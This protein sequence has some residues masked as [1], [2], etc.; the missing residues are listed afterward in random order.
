[1]SPRAGRRYIVVSGMAAL[2]ALLL[3]SEQAEHWSMSH[4]MSLVVL[5]YCSSQFVGRA[6]LFEVAAV[7]WPGR[8]LGRDIFS[9]L[10]LYV[11]VLKVSR[12]RLL[13][14]FLSFSWL[15]ISCVASKS[16]KPNSTRRRLGLA[17]AIKLINHPIMVAYS[18]CARSG[19]VLFYEGAAEKMLLL[20]TKEYG[21]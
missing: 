21:L 16:L 12:S 4:D 11:C 13:P 17:D 5:G 18:N 19:D 3:C 2:Y 10:A 9:L 8:G 7:Q 14:F 15:T 6:A 1:V 20:F